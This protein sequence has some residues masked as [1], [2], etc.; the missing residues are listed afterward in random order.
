[1]KSECI[2]YSVLYGSVC[3]PDGGRDLELIEETPAELE[4]VIASYSLDK[5]INILNLQR[6][7]KLH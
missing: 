6:I 7:K 3:Q 1:M 4:K 5:R 2:W